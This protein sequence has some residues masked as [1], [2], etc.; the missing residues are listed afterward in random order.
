[1]L[2]KLELGPKLLDL[3]VRAAWGAAV[4]DSIARRSEATLFERGTLYVTVES[5][6]WKNELVFIAKEVIERVNNRFGQ[7]VPSA[8]SNPV[9]NLKLQ[10]GAVPPPKPKPKPKPEPPPPPPNLHEARDVEKRIASITDPDLKD[11]AR[12][13]LLKAVRKR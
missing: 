2:A 8:S 3:R 12:S 4:G 9:Q 10:V 1:M 11:A 5:P 6:T 7:D 13:L